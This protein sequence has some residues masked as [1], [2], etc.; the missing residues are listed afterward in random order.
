MSTVTLNWTL[1]TTRVDGSPLATT[2]IDHVDIF[3]VSTADPASEKVATIPGAA[4]SFILSGTFTVGFHNYTAT[5]TDTQGNVSGPSNVAS[6]TVASTLS[7][8]SP[9]ADLTAV[10]AQ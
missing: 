6:L 1:P 8:P 2:D 5:V 9:I 4:T 7:P 3:D 10:F